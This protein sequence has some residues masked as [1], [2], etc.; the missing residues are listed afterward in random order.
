MVAVLEGKSVVVTGSGRG[1]GAA[2]AASAAEHGARVVVNDIDDAPV[3]A[4]VAAI[5]GAGGD[6]IGC[7][8]DVSQWSEAE[9]L[10]EECVSAFG[11]IDG[12]VNN[13]AVFG[14]NRLD[15]MSE[16]EL[17]T[18]LSVN[19]AGTAFCATHAVRRMLAQGSG[20]IVNVTSGAQAGIPTMGVY[21]ATKGAVASFTYAWAA[22]LAGTGVR[23][24][25]LS[26]MA[27]T[28]MV[29]I[30]DSYLAAQGLLMPHGPSPD[31]ETNAP[32]VVHLL[33]DA[34]AGLNG[35]VVRIEGTHLSTMTHPAVWL[36]TIERDPWT[37]DAVRAAFDDELGDR[38]SPIGVVG[39]IPD[40]DL[41]GSAF[42]SANA[43]E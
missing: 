15:E 41:Q 21:G 29:D 32:V 7:V 10:I 22:E 2:I 42:W 26:P 18:A 5:V 23:C 8:A 36:P 16:A 4:T 6:A 37:V 9:R 39:M 30:T 20:S 34:S 11:R 24:N 33:S 35:Q 14:M 1:I 43:D 40:I 19:V 25:A 13:A 12:L 28:R 31:P 38:L 17:R 3:S 27:R